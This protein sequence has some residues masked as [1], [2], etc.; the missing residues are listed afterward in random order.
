MGRLY[1]DIC[2]QTKLI[3]NNVD[4]KTKLFK[5]SNQWALFRETAETNYYKFK[6][7]DIAF[8]IRRVRLSDDVRLNH[9]E[10]LEKEPAI[11]PH[12]HV[13]MKT[14]KIPTSISDWSADKLF[15]GPLP[16][17]LYFAL[18]SNDAFNRAYGK[19][20]FKFDNQGVNH[21]TLYIDGKQIP[22]DPMTPDYTNKK[23]CR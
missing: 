7:T 21:I 3:P 18:S 10:R 8:Y 5:S 9:I 4:M 15:E 22:A 2:Q 11:Y 13:E 6:I 19:N 12:K 17:K 14:N 16:N 23:Y 1:L 20:P